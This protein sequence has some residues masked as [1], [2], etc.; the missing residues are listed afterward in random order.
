MANFQTEWLEKLGLPVHGLSTADIY[1]QI[2]ELWLE[3]VKFEQFDAITEQSI[4]VFRSFI[5]E[6]HPCLFIFDPKTREKGKGYLFG[7]RDVWE[8][9]DWIEKNEQDLEKFSYLITTQIENPG[10]GFVWSV[11]SD[12]KGNMVIETLHKPGVANHRALSQPTGD[13]SP[14]LCQCIVENGELLELRGRHFLDTSSFQTIISIYCDLEGYFEFVK[15][16]QWGNLG[17]FTTGIELFRGM[18]QF[19]VHLFSGWA[20]DL[21][22]RLRGYAFRQQ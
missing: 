17:I 21:D 4:S 18:I 2:R 6:N 15:W 9:L 20:I 12:G 8:I 14:Y 19:P 7:V 1:R 16:K 5:Q 13:L 11:F 22:A 10:T 3:T